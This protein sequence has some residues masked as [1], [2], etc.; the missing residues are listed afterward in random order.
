MMNKGE[1]LFLIKE[2]ADN[3]LTQIQRDGF[4]SP[5]HNGP[6]MDQD[7]P[8][9]NSA[10][11]LCTYCS[12]Y[13]IFGE[14]TYYQ[15]AQLLGEYILREEHYGVNG[16]VKF[17]GNNVSDSTNGVIGP[18]WVIEALVEA[19][20]TLED[21]RYYKKALNLFLL[22]EFDENLKLWKIVDI[23][24]Q[25]ISIDYVYNHQLWFA[26]AGS[27]ICQ[28]RYNAEI[29]RRIS[30]FLDNYK[31]NIVFQ[32]S[33]LLYHQVSFDYTTLGMLKK[34]IRS[35]LCDLS[36]GN[37]M[38]KQKHLEKGY[39]L[40]DLYGLALLRSR[41]KE[42]EI[43]RDPKVLKAVRYGLNCQNVRDLCDEKGINQYGFPYNSPA[44]EA[45]YVAYA[46]L[47][48][49]DPEVESLVYDIQISNFYDPEIKMFSKNTK[50][51]ETL[52]ARVY[53]WMRYY[54]VSLKEN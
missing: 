54:E 5:G 30:L 36:L 7:T 8:V 25:S 49:I 42:K 34:K 22:E 27:I 51:P 2:I 52:T 1:F 16:A 13:C 15:C 9:R 10:H 47:G 46:F 45:G 14:K 43:F 35:L 33:G 18:A 20:K 50:D 39:Q 40:F 38:A 12:L 6:Y 28:Y 31:N 11:W 19:A 48:K 21:E 41:Y 37:N 32:P 26:A 3:K 29:D 53:E 24:G 4:A 23:D 44:F 17:R